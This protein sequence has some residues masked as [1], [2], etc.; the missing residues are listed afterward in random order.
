[1]SLGGDTA[2]EETDMAFVMVTKKAE[3]P[4]VLRAKGTQRE[5]FQVQYMQTPPLPPRGENGR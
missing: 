5:E 1:M 4:M 3:R 2:R